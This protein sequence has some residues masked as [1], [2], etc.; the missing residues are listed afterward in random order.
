MGLFK[1][2]YNISRAEMGSD[3]TNYTYNAH[4][5][6]TLNEID[7]IKLNIVNSEKTVQEV[8]AQVNSAKNKARIL[9]EKAAD[10]ERKA[11]L[12]VSKGQSGELA[13]TESDR[14]A[15][16]A[17][18][19]MANAISEAEKYDTEART[20]SA[21][22]ETL[23]T[24]LNDLKQK[25]GSSNNEYNTISARKGID[26]IR[27]TNDEVHRYTDTSRTIEMLQRMK[28]K[29]SVQEQLAGVYVEQEEID[30]ELYN[31]EVEKALKEKEAKSVDAL[32]QLKEKMGN[33]NNNGI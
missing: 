28:D 26:E 7:I 4:L 6:N 2:I 12:L 23:G 11:M 18:H 19:L 21:K 16:E 14:L 9:R 31:I 13:V 22:M 10:Y 5:N 17:L 30:E 1:R 33:L 25:L 27:Q 29:I 20:L 24:S 15:A 32:Q 3:D 8:M